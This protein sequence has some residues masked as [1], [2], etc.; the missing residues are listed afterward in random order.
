MCVNVRA[1]I[2]SM[3]M[4][5]LRSYVCGHAYIL[6]DR[7]SVEQ[8]LC[9]SCCL[10]AYELY[11]FG[12]MCCIAAKWAYGREQQSMRCLSCLCQNG[13]VAQHSIDE[14]STMQRVKRNL[15]DLNVL[16]LEIVFDC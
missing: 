15:L 10:S 16:V 2:I 4:H 9:A 6:F 8:I 5:F 7:I 1:V 13:I 11:S 14:Y 3:H 12:L